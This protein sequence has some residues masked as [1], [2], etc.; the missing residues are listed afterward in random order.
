MAPYHVDSRNQ[1]PLVGRMHTSQR[2]SHAHHVQI[3]IALGEKT[4]LQS[5]VNTNNFRLFAKQLAICFHGYPRQFAVRPHL[6]GWIPAVYRH[7]S[8]CQLERCLHGVGHVIQVAHHIASLAH[9]HHAE[10]SAVCT[11]ATLLEV[12]TIQANASSWQ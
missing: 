6:P 10:S 7:L 5:S 12:S 9:G 2:G 11:L 3:G 1:Q 4:A 8:S